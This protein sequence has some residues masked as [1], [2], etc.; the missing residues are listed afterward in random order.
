MK[1]IQSTVASLSWGQRF[2]LIEAYKLSAE[3]ACEAFG[4]TTEE[5]TTASDLKGKGIFKIDTVMDVAPY[6]ELFGVAPVAKAP[7]T[8]GPATKKVATPKKRGRKGDKITTAFLAVPV[9]PV[10]VE[11]FMSEFGVSLAVLR[12]AKRFDTTE[13][14]ST[15]PVR[16]KK[17]NGILTICRPEAE[18]AGAE[19][20][21]DEA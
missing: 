1:N 10:S 20:V 17:V 7:R 2:A 6:G 14:A 21:A 8:A 15:R 18:V 11:A 4:V 12:Q 19:P 16:V 5:L 13:L 9:T 3:A